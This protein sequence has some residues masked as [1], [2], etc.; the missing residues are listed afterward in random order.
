MEEP[1]CLEGLDLREPRGDGGLIGPRPP[2]A[3]RATSRVAA[4]PAAWVLASAKAAA[5]ASWR[6]RN[7]A[8]SAD[9]AP[10]RRAGSRSP[11]GG[12]AAPR[13]EPTAPRT[14]A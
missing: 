5:Q 11:T 14:P 2:T 13:D 7:A 1:L 12:R 8:S 9:G 10:R 3:A 6:S 4:A